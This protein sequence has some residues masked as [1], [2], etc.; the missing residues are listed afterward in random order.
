MT[1]L[2]KNLTIKDSV[3]YVEC[4]E[5]WYDKNDNPSGSISYKKVQDFYKEFG[6]RFVYSVR[7]A[8]DFVSVIFGNKAKEF[9]GEV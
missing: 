4:V 6:E 3:K 2:V 5:N 9:V 7:Y 1:M 8:N